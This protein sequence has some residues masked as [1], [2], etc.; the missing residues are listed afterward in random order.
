MIES[1]STPTTVAAGAWRWALWLKVGVTLLLFGWIARMTNLSALAA[2]MRQLDVAVIVAGVALVLAQQVVLAWRWHR[3]VNW[4]GGRWSMAQSLGWVFVGLFFN[5][6]LPTAVGGDA[7]RILALHRAGMPPQVAVGSVAVERGSGLALLALMMAVA[8]ALLPHNLSGPEVEHALLLSALFVLTILTTAT[9]AD[10]WLT[11]WLPARLAQAGDRFATAIRSLF[12]TPRAVVELVAG[13]C[14]ATW[15]GLWAAVVIG[16]GLG[17]HFEASVF[18]AF[19]GGAILLT[20][21]P[22]SLGGWGVREAGMV[23]L[24]GHLGAPP[25][26]VVALSVVWGLL[27][28]VVALPGGAY[29]W[30]VHRRAANDSAN[31]EA[32]PRLPS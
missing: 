22:I 24:F 11:R 1:D 10:K 29:F 2:A 32:G 30:L 14:V 3:I 25:E 31:S 7:V 8:V 27:P 28:L 19:V 9:F 23:A 26:P 18:V 15:L 13:G 16:R 5:Q 4:L 17:L 6:A 20:L 12:R 21:L